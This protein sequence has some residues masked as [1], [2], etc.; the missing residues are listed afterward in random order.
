MRKKWPF[1]RLF[2]VSFAVITLVT[3]TV[4][5]FFGLRIIDRFFSYYVDKVHE[6]TQ[7]M[8]VMQAA[9][10]YKM[11]DTWSG[12]DG[13]ETGTIAKLSGDYFTITDNQGNTVYTS[14]KGVE[15]CCANPNHV[16]TNVKYPILVDGKRVGELS[17]GYF[18]NHITSPE[19]DAFRG[20]GVSLVVL[21]IICISLCGALVSI[22]FFYRLSR[23]VRDIAA[24]AKEISRGH[25]Q[26]RVV[27]QSSVAEM[28]EIADSI[29]TLGTSL[30]NQEKFRQQ[31][32]VDLSHELRTPLQ[33]LL[34]QIEAILDGIHKADA[35]RLEAMHAEITRTSELLN[36]LEDR[37]IYEND[38]F[39][40]NIAPTD[41][42][43]VARRVALGHEGGFAQKGLAFTC[44]IE[45]EIV[46]PAD[47]MRFA[48]VLINVL[49]NALK[50]TAEGHVSLSLQKTGDAVELLVAD[51]GEGMAPD[52]VEN[53]S[54]RSAQAFKA[55]NSK[56]V[57]LYIAKL[58]IDKHGWQ[59]QID[60]ANNIGT[61]VRIIM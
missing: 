44:D 33:I 42:S 17:A 10:H 11:F 29:N 20:S 26:S 47:S 14:E 28:H 6:E 41:I 55:V 12:Y 39:E 3:V 53:I 7:H 31:L 32:I 1:T 49:S 25:L 51:S 52:V 5:I 30:L 2:A 43:E 16:Y 40:L 46:I 61:R 38:T 18:T 60:S 24:T 56:G 59:L 58:I 36:E 45:S 8:L 9:S 35:P 37:L 13:T 57:G 19:A 54:K 21:A 23:P 22:L 34:N 48:Q 4:F 15:R 27:I 50:Y